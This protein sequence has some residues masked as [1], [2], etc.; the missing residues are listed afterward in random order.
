VSC[1]LGLAAWASAA[2]A[3]ERMVLQNESAEVAVEP[4]ASADA[5]GSRAQLNAN[6]GR[7]DTLFAASVERGAK[8][9]ET[10]NAPASWMSH[11]LRFEGGW[12][13]QSDTRLTLQGGQRELWTQTEANPLV[14]AD[15]Q[16]SIDGERYLRLRAATRVERLD[17]QVGAETSTAALDTRSLS[18]AT[19][20]PAGL[21][22]ATRKL[23]ASLAWN[24]S[25][26]VSLQAGA[27]AQTF[28]SGWEG[29]NGAA[30][31]ESYLT[32]SVTATLAPW[33]DG[34][35]RLQA[36]EAATPPDPAKFA[37]YAQIAAP[38]SGSAPRPDYGWRYALRFEQGLAGG[39][40]VGAEAT[41][42][43][44]ASVTELGPVGSGEA[45]VGAGPAKRRQIA[46]NM[47]APLD[48]I[49]L[50]RT[51]VTG[52]VSV[53]RSQVLDPFTQQPRPLSGEAPYSAS[54][55]LAGTLP[56]SA[57]SWNVTARA[58]GPESLYQMAQVTNLGA[59]AG[60]GG[61]VV[62]GAGPVRVSLEIDNLLGGS[63]DVTSLIYA[64][65][66]LE[67]QIDAVTRRRDVSRAVRI[68]LRRGL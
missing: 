24:A 19:G 14:G 68:A 57:V 23:S 58:E 52:E 65:S 29:Q 56:A 1:A 54:L 32:P 34:R 40:K 31:K 35:W 4:F 41:A 37:A 47:A 18:Q 16:L 12:T 13:G 30:A 9:W 53:R 51:T 48:P 44:L 62:Y 55:R 63:R 59:T 66:R 45:P 60:L 11:D 3:A 43:R 42:W 61:G 25:P 7:F 28:A 50:R 17:L 5:I 46:F 20:E 6:L 26:R 2:Q 22:T 27:A 38:E 10:V 64:G 67:D 49:G 36:E 8:G 15:G 21:W 39:V 33:T